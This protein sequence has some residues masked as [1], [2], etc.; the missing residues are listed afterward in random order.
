[1]ARHRPSLPE[2]WLSATPPEGARY[3]VRDMSFR[4]ARFHVHLTAK[5]SALTLRV[6]D[7]AQ[8]WIGK[9]HER[10]LLIKNVIINKN[11]FF[12]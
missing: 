12:L 7:A 8:G 5:R 9:T 11:T 6:E 1:M 10:G 3:T 4:G 2:H